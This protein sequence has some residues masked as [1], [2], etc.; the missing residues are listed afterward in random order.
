MARRDEKET[1]ITHVTI[2]DHEYP[3]Q[4]GESAEYTH[5][6]AE[7]VD[8]KMRDISSEKN[9]ADLTKVA[10]MAALDIA[11]QLLRS[12][13]NRETE[14]ERASQAVGRLGQLLDGTD[15]DEGG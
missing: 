12:R 1:R 8:R 14:G 2:Y 10:I 6:V 11:D 5:R 13:E 9:L 3:L 7:F 15:Q 4:T